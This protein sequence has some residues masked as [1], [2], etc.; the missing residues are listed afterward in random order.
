MDSYIK[1]PVC[2]ASHVT[3]QLSHDNGVFATTCGNCGHY[4]K[5][6]ADPP[7]TTSVTFKVNGTEVTVAA[8]AGYGPEASLNDYLR[9]S[10]MS[11]GT[12]VFCRQGGCGVCVVVAKIPLGA[13]QTPLVANINSCL[14]PL[15]CCDGWEVT[16]SEGLG[17]V[18][19]KLHPIQTAVSDNFGTQCGYCSPGHVMNMYGL[20]QKY[21]NMDKQFVEDNFEGNL[22]RCTGYRPILKAM[23]SLVPDTSSD[24]EDITAKLCKMTGRACSSKTGASCSGSCGDSRGAHRP[25]RLAFGATR[26]EKPMTMG[27]LQHVL[28]QVRGQKYRI[29]G[30][31]T[32]T[33]YFKQESCDNFDVVIDC[34]GIP[35]MHVNTFDAQT[36]TYTMGGGR[37]LTDL[38]DIFRAEAAKS[39]DK[40]NF[41][42][43]KKYLY[44]VAS[45]PIRNRGTWAGNLMMKNKYPSF[46]SDVFNIMTV[47][48]AK[49]T[50]GQTPNDVLTVDTFF[51]AD[52]TGKVLSKATFQTFGAND[53][54]VCFKVMPR[55]QNSLAL[56]NAAFRMP[57]DAIQGFLI[58][59]QPI[60][61]IGGISETFHRATKTETYLYGKH[62]SAPST[63]AGALTTLAGELFPTPGLVLPSP[64]YRKTVA[65]ALLYKFILKVLGSNAGYNFRSGVDVL[66]DI[67]PLSS[68]IQTYDNKQKADWPV[69][70]AVKKLEGDVQVTGEAQFTDDLPPLPGQLCAAIITATVGNATIQSIDPQ[71]AMTVP[72]VVRVLTAL[73]IP[74]ANDI[75]VPQLLSPTGN[76]E[77]EELF[78]SGK[79][80][81]Y[82]QPIGM[83]VAESQTLAD[84]AA[85][86]VKVNYNSISAPV[87]T[88]DDAI[89]AKTFFP[90]P[91]P[92]IVVGDPDQ[93]ISSAA[94][95]ISGVFRTPEQIH[96]H[97]ETQ[98]TNV[99]PTEDG[100]QV[101]STTQWTDN[102]QQA[103]SQ[104]T[105][106]PKNRIDVSVKRMGG[107]YGGKITRNNFIAAAC[108]LA[109]KL[110]N[111]PVRGRMDIQSNLEACGRRY[112]H[113]VDFRV[114][115]DDTGLLKGIDLNIY[116]N[117][118]FLPN[119]Q[120]GF[121]FSCY[122]DNSYFCANWRI[123]MNSLRTN[124]A[125][126]TAVRAPASTPAVMIIENVLEE[127]ARV[128]NQDPWTVKQLNFYHT[129]QVTPIGMK[130][131]HCNI[132]L[133]Y[134]QL[135][136]SAQVHTRQELFKFYNQDNRWKKRALAVVPVKFGMSS[137]FDM[138]TAVVSI[139]GH[140]GTIAVT[141]GGTECGQGINTKVAQVVAYELG[142]PVD[143]VSVKPTD[144]TVAAN[145]ATTGG[146]TTSEGCCRAAI[147]CCKA[148]NLRITP[149]KT[150]NPDLDWAKLMS[151]CVDVGVALT[152]SYTNAGK[153]PT[154]GSDLFTYNVYGATCSEVELDVLTGEYQINRV[155][156]VYDCG[157]SLN[158]MVDIGQ[159]EGA[160][161]MGLGLNLTEAVKYDPSTGQMLCYD[162]WNY[163]PPTNK[164]IPVDFRVSLLKNAPNPVGVLGSKGSGEPPLNT[165]V[166]VFFALRKCIE[167]ARKDAGQTGAFTF[168]PPA[169]VESVQ[170]LCA[171][172]TTQF[173][174]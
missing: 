73:D 166:S 138:F 91:T 42:E 58:T 3:T 79:V 120:L 43:L 133:V 142:V 104:V 174:I 35:E 170:Q 37:T 169:T 14:A 153:H 2:N 97:M 75:R 139:Y 64:E 156:I 144:S 172:N 36:N 72:G 52:M 19:T 69:H 127:V 88:V 16:T 56:V 145:N 102:T 74:G 41:N 152:E 31:N 8:D 122:V 149:I 32:G 173:H 105:G 163:H 137:S 12:K 39:T 23:K 167:E 13:G 154:G 54:V 81:Y 95:S 26:W 106:I 71:P 159:V 146:S 93:A 87:I 90:Q 15:F 67:R 40:G 126:T 46:P 118:G 124:I 65:C 164:D 113:R 49:L 125:M 148:V 160:F 22:C 134:Q 89:A 59:G 62:L 76:V 4:F 83:V 92:P 53:V 84:K 129:G 60:I 86:L 100:L 155:D 38:M 96:F 9:Q 101:V 44:R 141:H 57:I 63:I 78:C 21:P 11:R 77:L 131:N 162:T 24:I 28:A 6:R 10:G 111:R 7:F 112:Q 5:Y 150:A 132:D 48:G 80:M 34:A 68:G 45:S 143:M 94:H 115:F 157:E 161:V 25:I 55:S 33:G 171:T 47:L 136:T 117:A 128:V 158:P 140:D 123:N 151:K 165:A 121:V 109:A 61:S 66:H 20:M 70:K 107:A 135:M 99:V 85:R 103:I 18:K 30:A 29:L 110:T 147:E 130:L 17:S 114:G 27:D 1:C 108:G 82:G 50:V 98:A 51:K 119:E 116:E 168:E